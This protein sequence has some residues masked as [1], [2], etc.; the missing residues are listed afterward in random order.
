M[1]RRLTAV[2]VLLLLLAALLRSVRFC[3]HTH[4]QY[5]HQEVVKYGSKIF[6][7]L[8]VVFCSAGVAVVLLEYVGTP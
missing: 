3:D 1:L 7:S 5:G 4:L 6:I 8:V 2:A